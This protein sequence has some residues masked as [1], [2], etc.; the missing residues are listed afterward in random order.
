MLHG[1]GKKGWPRC[2][3]AEGSTPPGI[4]ACIWERRLCIYACF[5]AIACFL[6]I[7]GALAARFTEST[8]PP[9]LRRRPPSPRR[10]FFSIAR[11]RFIRSREYIGIIA[12]R[13]TFLDAKMRVCLEKRLFW[14]L[15]R[16]YVIN[17]FTINCLVSTQ[18][19][20]LSGLDNLWHL[21]EIPRAP[22]LLALTLLRGTRSP[23][24]SPSSSAF[25][26]KRARARH[27]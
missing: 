10:A 4:S 22:P 12:I 19:V 24:I 20:Y 5:A 7:T 15:F 18:L 6:P 1:G 3:R 11:K 17:C 25:V 27:D 8:Q 14:F 23:P 21:L 16:I 26:V 9:F 13:D 2:C